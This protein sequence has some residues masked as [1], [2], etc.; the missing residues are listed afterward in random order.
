M[1]SVKVKC[2]TCD[3]YSRLCSCGS[4]LRRSILLT[5]CA[6]F[7]K[8]SPANKVLAAGMH[9]TTITCNDCNGSGKI[10]KPISS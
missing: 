2:E 4:K 1:S 3:G 6:A 8:L 10:L 5:R 9:D 7:N